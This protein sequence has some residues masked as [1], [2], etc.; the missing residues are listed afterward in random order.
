MRKG[1]LAMATAETLERPVDEP[2][3]DDDYEHFE[4][5]NGV[6]VELPPMSA[7]ST[8]VANVLAALIN[9]YAARQSQ[10]TAFNEMLFR[11]PVNGGRNRRPDVAYLSAERLAK[12]MP[13]PINDN[14]WDTVPDLAVEVTSPH[15]LNISILEK[16]EE[17]FEAGVL[18]VWIIHPHFQVAYAYT[19]FSQNRIVTASERLDGGEVL[20]G[21]QVTLGDLFPPRSD[22]TKSP[23]P[24]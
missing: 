12:S 21:F 18:L 20:A 3:I 16:I 5:V 13:I 7:Y 2:P 15:D 6:R 9:S 14:A 10:G 11:L 22:V 19:S 23:S 24:G 1:G 8:Y 17:Y 4:E